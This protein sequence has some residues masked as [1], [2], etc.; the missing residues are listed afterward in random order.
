MT[1]D[2]EYARIVAMLAHQQLAPYVA[3]AKNDNVT[4]VGHF[5]KQSRVVVRVSDGTIVSGESSGIEAG[6]YHNRSNPVT[7]PA[8]IASCYRPT[9]ESNE[10][11]AGRPALRFTLEPTCATE[12]GDQTSEEYPF[13]T[14]HADAQTLAPLNLSGDPPSPS[15]KSP[16]MTR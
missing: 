7:H 3:Y 16:V 4:G 14:L 6:D 8:F 2:A 10:T 15:L 13:S 5:D 11:Y 9:A 12:H 1:G